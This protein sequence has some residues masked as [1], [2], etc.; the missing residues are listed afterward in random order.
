[1]AICLWMSG[2]RIVIPYP[3]L[4]AKIPELVAVKCHPLSEIITHGIPN[5]QTRFFHIK[6]CI[7]AFVIIVKGSASTHF[8]K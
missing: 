8:V 3:Q 2:G 6:C 7:L 5:R 1:M 4:L